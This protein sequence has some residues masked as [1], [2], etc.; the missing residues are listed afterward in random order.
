VIGYAKI[1]VGNSWT[2]KLKSEWHSIRVG[3]CVLI[4]YGSLIVIFEV[5]AVIIEES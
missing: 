2:V 3:V 5:I 1:R 4:I